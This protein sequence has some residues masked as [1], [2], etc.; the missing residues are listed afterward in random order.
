MAPTAVLQEGAFTPVLQGS[1]LHCP[2]PSLTRGHTSS[3]WPSQGLHLVL[4]PFQHLALC[5]KAFLP[6][7]SLCGAQSTGLGWDMELQL[8]GAASL[9]KGTD[10]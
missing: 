2:L 9:C 1:D 10:T 6:V 5:P 7:S 8:W 4:S 3:K